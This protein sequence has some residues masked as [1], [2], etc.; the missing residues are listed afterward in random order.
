MLPANQVT[1][2]SHIYQPTDDMSAFDKLPSTYEE[3]NLPDKL[4]GF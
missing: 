1:I 3:N 4:L 2:L